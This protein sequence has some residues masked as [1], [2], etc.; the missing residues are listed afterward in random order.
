MLSEILDQV[1]NIND[2]EYIVKS[3][4]L[5][6]PAWISLPP[7]PIPQEVAGFQDPVRPLHCLLPICKL[8]SYRL[9]SSSCIQHNPQT[10]PSLII[11][12]TC[13][14]PQCSGSTKCH[15]KT[16]KSLPEPASRQTHALAASN[17]DSTSPLQH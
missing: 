11:S 1:M 14:L 12:S 16:I 5:V 6:V 13:H 17:V 3:M 8:L 4:P 2:K 10:V 7:S 9:I 15:P